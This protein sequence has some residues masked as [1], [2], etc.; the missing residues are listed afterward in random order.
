MPALLVHVVVGLVW[1]VLALSR[2][3]HGNRVQQLFVVPVEGTA[4]KQEG[5]VRV[6]AVLILQHV[7]GVKPVFCDEGRRLRDDG[8]QLVA[9]RRGRV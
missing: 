5:K 2:S 9:F 6:V 7:L 3:I 1:E 4:G 8:P